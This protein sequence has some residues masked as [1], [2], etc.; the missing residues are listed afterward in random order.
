MKITDIKISAPAHRALQQAGITAIEQLSQYTE[1]Q[2]LKLHGFGPKAICILK[3]RGVTFKEERHTKDKRMKIVIRESDP[4]YCDEATA[5][6]RQSY[7]EAVSTLPI[8]PSD[9]QM[10]QLISESVT[11]LFRHGTGILAFADDRLVGYMLGWKVSELFGPVKGIFSPMTGHCAIKENRHEIYAQMLEYGLKS[12]VRQGFLSFATS[13]MAYDKELVD[14]FFTYGFGLRCI[15]ALRKAEPLPITN[16]DI[17]IIKAE[18]DDL[19]DIAALHKE[20]HEYYQ[21]SPIFMPRQPE[22]ALADLQEWLSHP[23]RHLWVAKREGKALGYI[24]IQPEGETS[25]SY[26][27]QIMNVTGAYVSEE[28]RSK[29]VASLLLNEVQLWLND[30]GISCCGVDY[31]AINPAATRFW[32]RYFT[33]YTYSVTRRIDE[34]IIR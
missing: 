25:V 16:T 14:E 10:M 23:N 28:S 17:E 29:G 12:W 1:E 11:S 21:Y 30:Q 32:N 8:L 31:E 22:D 9:E 4:T 5:L 26:H 27:S 18:Q 19:K 33:P 3:E 6:L 13:V 2:L 34:R 7:I 20:H 15:D 24:R